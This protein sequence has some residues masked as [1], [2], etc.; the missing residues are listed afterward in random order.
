MH[1]KHRNKYWSE[2]ED[3]RCDVCLAH[4]LEYDEGLLVYC[5]GCNVVVHPDCYRL[6]LLKGIPK[7]AWLCAR[8][9]DYN[10]KK[11]EIYCF[12]CPRE[13]TF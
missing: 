2:C 9:K 12:L 8:C 1:S 11:K 3:D 10:K 5:D 6:D 7:G 13:K 4:K